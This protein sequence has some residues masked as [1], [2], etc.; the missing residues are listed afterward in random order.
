MRAALDAL[1]S[2]LFPAACRLCGRLLTTASR[3]PVCPNCL[4]RVRP[5]ELLAFCEQCQR[6]LSLASQ[7]TEVPALCGACR[8]GETSFDRLRTFGAYDGE[9][10]ELIVL[11]KYQAVRSLA[12]TLGG[13]LALVVKRNPELAEVDALVPVPLHPRRQRRRRYNQAELLA[14]DLA[15]CSRLPV[16]PGWLSRVKDTPSQTGLTHAQRVENVR[17]A[18]ATIAKL[19][20]KRILLVDDV[21]TTGATL[22]ACARILKQAGAESVQAITAARVLQEI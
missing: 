16:E 14:R 19:D 1:A 5:L 8:Q 11:L 6:P 21:C 7:P 22:N 15:R 20:R 4:G 3:V 9:L 13:W 10:R 17:G 18:F 2:V 12:E